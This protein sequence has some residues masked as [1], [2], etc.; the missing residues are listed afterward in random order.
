MNSFALDR[1]AAQGLAGALVVGSITLACLLAPVLAPQQGYDTVGDVWGAFSAQAWLG[2]DNLGRDMLARLLHGGRITLLLAFASTLLALAAGATLGLVAAV[3]GGKTDIVLSR[4]V[5]TFM[6]IPSL[7]SAL[8]VLSAL[9]TSIPILV[10]TIAALASTRVFRLSRALASEIVALDY[11]EAARLRKESLAWL[12]GREVLPNMLMPLTTEFGMR[13]CFSFLL[14][15]AL[16]FLGL[17]IQPPLAD[18]GSMVR[19]NASAIGLGGI[20]P[21]IPAAAISLFVVGVNLMVGWSIA[22]QSQQRD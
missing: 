7:I 6:S 21:L 17:G 19:D 10:C 20:A 22:L 5:D 13:L 15:A 2:Y 4:L 9:G 18:W 12:I 3:V 8:V 11:F 1:T 16:S 14:I